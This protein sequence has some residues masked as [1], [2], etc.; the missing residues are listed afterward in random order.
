MEKEGIKIEG[1]IGAWHVIAET[2]MLQ[3]SAAIRELEFA[4]S[5]FRAYCPNKPTA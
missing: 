2:F 3:I 4:L 1:Y 5:L